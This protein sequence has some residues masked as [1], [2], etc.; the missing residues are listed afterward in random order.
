MPANASPE[1]CHAEKRFS[2]ATTDEERLLAMEEMLKFV[3]QHKSAEALR[4]NLR[5]R[6]K[7]FKEKIAKQKKSG[8][9]TQQG[10]KKAEMQAILVGPPNSGKS[11]LFKNLTNQETL[12]TPHPHST[13]EPILGTINF[14]DVKIQLIDTPSFPNTDRGLL[15]TTD[16]ILLAIEKLE[17]VESSI[18]EIGSTNAKL[19]LVLTK[20]DLLNEQEKRKLEAN[21]KSKFKKYNYI[22]IENKMNQEKINEIKKTLFESFPIIRIYTKEPKKEPSKE[23]MILKKNSTLEDAAKKISKS[24]K[25][26]TRFAKI[27]GPSSKFAG[28]TVGLNHIL[29]DKD[30]IEIKT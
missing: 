6:Y 20:R 1:Y 22:L 19:F 7:K 18:K 12:I 30:I 9:S 5:T 16:I 26:Q 27:W 17:Q 2:E 25:N 3:P 14:E 8:K 29:K 13:I 11:T 28:Q 10:I 21:L 4:A 24:L 23:P 15:H